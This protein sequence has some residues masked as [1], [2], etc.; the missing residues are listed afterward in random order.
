[1]GTD[2]QLVAV[3]QLVHGAEHLDAARRQHDQVVA[4]PFQVGEQVGGQHHRHPLLGHRAHQRLEELAAGQRVEAGERL[5]QQQQLRPPGKGER[6]GDLG[7]LPA[8]QGPHPPVERHGDPLQP[9]PGK[10][11]VEAA[12]ELAAHGEVLAGGEVTVEGVVLG[13][14]ADLGDQPGGAGRLAEHADG[15]GRGGQ[16][17][18]GEVEQG[19]LAG[20]VG[21]DK[22]SDATPGDGQVAVPE[23]PGAPVALAE[24]A[25]LQ[26]HAHATPS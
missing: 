10:R 13:D 21:A 12:V 11:E 9:L 8:G 1:M 7:A 5:V 23:G 26:R 2:Q 6:Q 22:G 18:D 20:P 17:A 24:P 15:A 3:Q 14:E 25:G 4:D 16:Q 19:G